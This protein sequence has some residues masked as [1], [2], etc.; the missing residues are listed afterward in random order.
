MVIRSFIV[1]ISLTILFGLMIVNFLLCQD[2]KKFK[3]DFQIKEK[4]QVDSTSTIIIGSVNLDN[5]KQELAFNIIF[6]KQ[7]FWI[8]RD[9]IIE[10]YQN[11]SLVFEEKIGSFEDLSV[12]NEL[13]RIY[14]NDYGLESLGFVIKEVLHDSDLS[15]VT[16]SPSKSFETFI[17]HAQTTVKDNVLISF[18]IFDKDN[19]A[20]NTTFFS[21]YETFKGKP[22]PKRITSKTSSSKSHIFKSIEF[23]NI[24]AE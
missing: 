24:I 17:S 1:K 14:R 20:I 23:E 7:E 10:K 9:S 18:A 21:N 15:L 8:L 16:W 11:D 13:L 12:F 3:A 4:N 22:I 6:P 5:I 19:K 2:L